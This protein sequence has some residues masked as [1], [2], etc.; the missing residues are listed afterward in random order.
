MLRITVVETATE[1]R[2]TLEGRLVGPW[3]QELKTCWKNRH[4]AQNGRICTLDLSAVTFIDKGG[5]R[6]LRAISKEGP[7]FIATGSYNTYVLEQLRPVGN[8]GLLKFVSCFLVPFL[9]L[10]NPLR[11]SPQTTLKGPK[12]DGATNSSAELDSAFHRKGT[13]V[14]HVSENA[15]EEQQ[16]SQLNSQTR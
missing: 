4:R 10:A 8:R 2:W 6:L 11:P 1:Q 5:E 13:K 15:N 14:T 16:R 3:V 9:G 7:Q 12:P